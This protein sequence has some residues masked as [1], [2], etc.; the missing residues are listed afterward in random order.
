MKQ[1]IETSRL[2]SLLGFLKPYRGKLTV[3]LVAAAIAGAIPG[4]VAA[5]VKEFADRS[6]SGNISGIYVVAGAIVGLYTMLVLLRYIQGTV[7][8][9]VSLRVGNDLRRTLYSHLLRMP[10]TYFDTQRTGNLMSTMTTDVAKLQ[11]AANWVKDSIALPITA[12]TM[13]VILVRTSPKLVLITVAVVPLMALAIQQITRRLRALSQTAQGKQAELNALM[14]ET[15]S[16][17]RVIKAFAAEERELNRFAKV[18]DGAIHAQMRGI[19]RS[20]L[21][22]P[23]VDWI[24]SIAMAVILVIGAQEIALHTSDMQRVTKEAAAAGLLGPAGDIWV[25]ARVRGLSIGGFLQFVFAANELSR[26]IGGMGALRGALLD[27]F[28]AVDRIHEEVLDVHPEIADDPDAIDLGDVKGALSL[29]DVTYGYT[30]ETPVLCGVTLEIQPG[31][32][33]AFVGATGSGKSTLVDLIPRFIDPWTGCVKLDGLDLRKIKQ[34]SLRSVMAIVPQKTVLFA[35]TIFE[36]IAYGKPGATPDDVELAARAAGAHGFVMS[37]PDGYATLVGERGAML[38]GG[39][40]Q[41]IAIARALVCKPRVL[42]L[43]EAT[44]ALDSGTEAAVQDAIRAGSHDRTTLVVAHRLS[45]IVDADR[46]VVMQAGSIV[47]IGTHDVLVAAGGVYA[48][49]VE[50]QLRGEGGES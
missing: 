17:P 48:R 39:Q 13:A 9:E 1:K 45:T 30:L 43:D 5:A 15:L 21:L 14:D 10:L 38:S 23:S 31:E 34:G 28:G 20:A 36:N 40:A 2:K 42:I 26:A 33:V 6:G 50:T 19:R 27:M 24:G 7:L 8:A 41:R 18:A 22:G 16:S 46:I 11:N 37:K 4:G 25:A 44:S 12:A 32:T 29:E 47:E 3:G 49:L 35:G